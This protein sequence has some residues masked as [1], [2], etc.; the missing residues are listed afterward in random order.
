MLSLTDTAF[1]SADRPEEPG[2]KHLIVGLSQ[3]VQEK[4]SPASWLWMAT[5]SDRWSEKPVFKLVLKQAQLDRLSQ[6][7]ALAVGLSFEPDS[8][9]QIAISGRDSTAAD[10]TKEILAQFVGERSTV[11]REGNWVMTQFPFDIS[12]ANELFRTLFAQL[13]DG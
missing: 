6:T 13:T 8:M 11:E 4:L 5:D 2:G 10:R 3:T 9:A 1:A 12:K 7:R